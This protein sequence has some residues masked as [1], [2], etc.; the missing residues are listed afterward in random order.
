ME[1]SAH[2]KA[3]R[4]HYNESFYISTTLL[5]FQRTWLHDACFKNVSFKHPLKVYLHVW[6]GA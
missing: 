2:V 5:K 1:N 3:K 6:S 4:T